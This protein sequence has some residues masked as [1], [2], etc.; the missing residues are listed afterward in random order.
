MAKKAAEQEAAAPSTPS[1]SKAEGV[2][3]ALATGIESPSDIVDFLKNQYGIDMTK[4]MVSS[5]KSQ[6]KAR[7][8]KT[9][10]PAPKGKPGRKPKAASGDVLLPTKPPSRSDTVLLETLEALKP[11]I[12]THGA[13]RVKRLVDLLG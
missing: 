12:A 13:E 7:D 9:E 11:L 5:Y 10:A 8:S 6:Q 3:S 1:V 2:R 4:Q